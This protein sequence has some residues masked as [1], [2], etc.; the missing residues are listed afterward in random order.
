VQVFV[1]HVLILRRLDQCKNPAGTLLSVSWKSPGNLIGWICGQ[2]V[3]HIRVKHNR[4]PCHFVSGIGHF[5]QG[6]KPTLPWQNSSV[7]S[8]FRLDYCLLSVTLAL[9]SLA[10]T[11][12]GNGLR[13]KL[14]GWRT[15]NSKLTELKMP[16]RVPNC[17]ESMSICIYFVIKPVL[18]NIIIPL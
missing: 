17:A 15:E 14:H 3:L 6:I 18:H 11:L 9:K 1:S 12:C 7:D 4:P 8:S 5:V 2:P 10:N 13:H 16:K